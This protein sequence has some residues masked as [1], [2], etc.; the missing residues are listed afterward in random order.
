MSKE[1][2]QKERK[3]KDLLICKWPLD[4]PKLR[5]ALLS[6]KWLKRFED[7]EVTF[8]VL[9]ELMQKVLSKYPIRFNITKVSEKS[10]SCCIINR[11]ANNWI[12]TIYFKYFEEMVYKAL[13]VLYGYNILG[14]KFME[15][16]Q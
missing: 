13:I 14:I 12:E 3:I 2:M 15:D 1:L 16:K 7:E 10:Y 11:E 5:K 8:E 6:T 9:E 4:K